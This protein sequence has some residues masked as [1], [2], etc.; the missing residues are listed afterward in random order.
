[1]PGQDPTGADQ[2]IRVLIAEDQPVI[3]R[4]FAAMLGMESDIKVVAQAADG[5]EAMRL[6]RQWRP[7]IVL[8]DLQMPRVG[9]IAAMKR[10]LAD[11]PGCQVIVLT[12]F[13]TDELVF[14]AISSGAQAYLLK[15]ASEAEILDTIR[16]VRRGESRI[17]PHIARKVFEEFRRARPEGNAPRGEDELPLEELSDKEER[18][19]RLIADGRSNKDI[20][21][22]VFLAEG[23]VKNY[24]SRVMEKLQAKS[25][26]ELAVKA[27]R[28]PR[29]KT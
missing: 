26:T 9:G 12:T 8:M 7:D 1:M 20:A 3:R 5:S 11:V 10:I 27:L 4:A 6:A 16:A 15:D 2:T 22:T 25:R 18:I 13:D 29:A 19:L 17:S 14:E 23:T 21:D 28:R 24:V